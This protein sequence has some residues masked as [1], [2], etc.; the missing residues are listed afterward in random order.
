MEQVLDDMP[1]LEKTR[2]PSYFCC[3]YLSVCV[4]VLHYNVGARKVLYVYTAIKGS[5]EVNN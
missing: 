3:T 2:R 5:L 1:E 4:R